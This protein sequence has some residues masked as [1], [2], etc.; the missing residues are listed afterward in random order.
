MGSRLVLLLAVVA[1]ITACEASLDPIVVG[2]NCPEQPLRRPEQFA[3]V[4]IDQVIDDFE[5][6]DYFLYKVAGRDGTWTPATDMSSSMIFAGPSAACAAR[7]TKGGNFSGA[8]FKAHG[9][10][11]TGFFANQQFSATATPYDI[12]GYSGISFWAAVGKGKA[13]FDLELGLS[14]MDS[15]PNSGGLC[16]ILP[17]SGMP[18]IPVCFDY[19]KTT[20]TLTH[21]WQRFVIPLSN[22]VNMYPQ[23]PLR[24]K[25]AVG[26]LV[27]PTQTEFDIWFDDIRFED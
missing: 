9:A 24:T 21:T 22:L 11:L 8:G 6:G 7:G 18:V 17:P 15:V 3:D 25:A 16:G 2:M 19:Y 1:S 27:W 5:D 12:S 10:S 23:F 20:V 26:L 4:P 14:T 13:P